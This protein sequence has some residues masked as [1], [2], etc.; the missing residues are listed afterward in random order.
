MTVEDEWV[1]LDWNDGKKHTLTS[2][3]RSY[4][5]RVVL[6]VPEGVDQGR[7]EKGKAG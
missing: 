6:L 3:A 4:I 1:W 7:H 2:R 5:A